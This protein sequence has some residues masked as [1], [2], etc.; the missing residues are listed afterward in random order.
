MKKNDDLPRALSQAELDLLWQEN[1]VQ[2][3]T[4]LTKNFI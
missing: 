3:Y 1:Q 2:S 4:Q